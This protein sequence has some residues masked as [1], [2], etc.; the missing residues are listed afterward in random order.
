MGRWRLIAGVFL[1]FGLGILVGVLSTGLYMKSRHPYFQRGPEMGRAKLLGELKQQ[2]ELT[3]KQTTTLNKLVD[4]QEKDFRKHREKRTTLILER[5]D[6]KL[7]LSEE[8]R[9]KVKKILDPM[10]DEFRKRNSEF[11]RGLESF[12]RD[13]FAQV[14]KELN[15]DQQERFDDILKTLPK[16]AKRFKRPHRKSTGD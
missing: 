3:E 12:A 9:V 13:R 6:Q 2:L 11:R 1:V 14:K 4:R 16:P 8:Q 15:P 10:T 7:D 5:L